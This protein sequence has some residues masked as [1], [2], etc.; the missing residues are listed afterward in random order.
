MSKIRFQLFIFGFGILIAAI[1]F[2]LYSYTGSN[3]IFSDALESLVN[4]TASLITLYS[5]Y[6]ASKPKDLAHPYGHGKIEFVAAGIEGSL[7]LVAGVFTIYKTISDYLISSE[8]H[9][10]MSFVIM[11][12]GLG[13]SNYVLGYFSKQKGM[14]TNS[15]SLIAS[16]V[17]LQSDALT[18]IGI[19]VSLI[20]IY[21]TGWDMIDTI[22][23]ILAGLFMIYQG[24]RVFKRSLLDILDT[25][26]EEMLSKVIDYLQE[27]R[28][29]HMIDIHNFRIIKYGS[30]YHIDA[31]LTLPYYFTNLEVHREMKEVHEM[32]NEHFNS[33][34]ELFIH[35]DPCESFCCNYCQILDCQVRKEP[36]QKTIVWTLDNVLKNEKH[37]SEN[38][39]D[40][41]ND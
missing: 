40:R 41:S 32:I 8:V 29:E 3:A 22:I 5:L 21:L 19:L 6:L 7:L 24:F 20:V 15:P 26:D 16:G 30:E 25:A 33:E 13:L 2:A 1:K 18:S 36:F 35:P 12:V 23:A 14:K 11:T 39:I 31:H 17:H 4:V 27:K 34:V 38:P 28:D 37:G 9:V 10:H